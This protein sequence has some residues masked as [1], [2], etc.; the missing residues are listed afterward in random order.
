MKKN[1]LKLEVGDLIKEKSFKI[2][3]RIG[4]ITAI[5]DDNQKDPTFECILVNAKTLI[6]VENFYGEFKFFK[7]KRNNVKHYI[8]K[9]KLFKKK[10]F[11]IGG[12]ISYKGIFKLKYGRIICFL[13]REEGLYPKSYDLYKHNG[14]DLL[15][16]VE[17]NP[18]NLKRV[19]GEEGHPQIFIA[20]P[21]HASIIN[22]VEKDEDGKTII[23]TRL[24]I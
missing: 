3:R 21:N 2:K 7:I 22:A 17:I 14:K 24:D 11:E 9:N 19:L 23:P 12:Y 5:L 18:N 15:E 16:C 20:D 8:P 6:P 10:S 4:Q 13:N 1:I